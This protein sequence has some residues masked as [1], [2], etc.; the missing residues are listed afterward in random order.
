MANKTGFKTV[1]TSYE[2]LDEIEAEVRR[3][4][5]RIVRRIVIVVVVI[6]SIVAAVQ[7]WNA[8]RTYDSFEVIS[9]SQQKDGE[10]TRYDTFQGNILEYDNDGIVCRNT[11]GELVWNQ[12]FEMTSPIVS[13]CGEYLAVYDRTGTTVY[14]MSTSGLVKKIE[15]TTPINR[16]C[17]AQQGTIAVLMKED[18]VSYIKLYDKKGK[19]LAGGEFYEEKGSFP[20]DIALSADAKKLAVD[21]LDVTKGKISTTISFYNFGS[22]G[23]NEINNIVGSFTYEDMFVS[24]I[25]YAGEN[26]LLA[27]SDS[28]LLWFDGSQK[29]SPKKEVKF[30]QKIQSVFHNEKYVGITYSDPEKENSWHIKVYDMN[31]S[32]VMENDTELAYKKIEFL[33]NNEVCVRDDMHCELFTIHSIKK[34]RYTFDRELYKVLSG[35]DEQNYTFVMS[36]ETD[37]VRLR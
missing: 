20:V 17:I 35:A 16:V 5:H 36:G 37:E 33:D 8:L 23:Q 25:M 34:F 31:G 11:G 7:L 13:I 22:V 2:D 32:T 4:R 6:A 12:S 15:T 19:E 1:E 24:E 9:S 26:R 21:M 18:D 30:E 10:A 29:P 28:G 27:V 3:H 14:I